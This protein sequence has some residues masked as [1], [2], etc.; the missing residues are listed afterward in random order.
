M[1]EVERRLPVGVADVAAHVDEGGEE[2]H[3]QALAA[4]MNRSHAVDHVEG[5]AGVGVAARAAEA[6]AGHVAVHEV[7]QRAAVLGHLLEDD[8]GVA[9]LVPGEARVDEGEF[10]GELVNALL[11]GEYVAAAEGLGASDLAAVHGVQEYL[12]GQLLGVAQEDGGHVDALL[13]PV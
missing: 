13:A 6:L 12:H 9:A 10:P 5:G 2:I 1:V 4:A 3:G 11:R 7:A 8:L